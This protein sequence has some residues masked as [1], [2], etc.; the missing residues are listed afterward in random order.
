MLRQE[1]TM[2][3]KKSTAR[4]TR[5]TI[6]IILRAFGVLRQQWLRLIMMMV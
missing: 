3:V 6:L 2:N 1:R 5:S 4:K